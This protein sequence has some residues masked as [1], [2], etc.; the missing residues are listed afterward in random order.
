MENDKPRFT[1][2]VY[3]NDYNK[4]SFTITQVH[5]SLSSDD[6]QEGIS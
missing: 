6:N 4:K 3:E 5:E 2:S 1:Q